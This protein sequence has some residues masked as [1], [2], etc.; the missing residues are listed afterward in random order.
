MPW[1][2]N[3]RM[4]EWQAAHVLA[5]EA[6]QGSQGLPQNTL[7]GAAALWYGSPSS[8]FVERIKRVPQNLPIVGA[9]GKQA[10][11]FDVILIPGLEQPP[12]PRP[13]AGTGQTSPGIPMPSDL[14]LP[15]GTPKNG[16]SSEPAFWT[17]GKVAVA[18]AVGAG[19]LAGIV[20]FATRPK[21]NP[22]R[23]R[24]R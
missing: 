17:P 23:R 13:T 16:A 22:R 3:D 19:A 12:L 7:E 4:S 10:L 8:V 1:F 21:R 11:D 9:D 5:P 15:V 20:Y 6:N 14:A 2:F 24:R 18:G